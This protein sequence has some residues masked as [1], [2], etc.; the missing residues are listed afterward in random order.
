MRPDALAFP[1]ARTPFRAWRT[2]RTCADEAASQGQEG[3]GHE[4][5]RCGLVRRPRL[6]PVIDDELAREDR[7][8]DELQQAADE[9]LRGRLA[10]DKVG[11]FQ[12]VADPPRCHHLPPE[13]RLN[14]ERGARI[15][16]RRGAEGA[17][18]SGLDVPDA[19]GRAGADNLAHLRDREGDLKGDGERAENLGKEVGVAVRA[20]D[21][22]GAAE[23][24][25]EAGQDDE[26]VLE[27]VP[28][29]KV[30]EDAVYRSGSKAW[31]VRVE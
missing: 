21:V 4:G 20:D 5:G 31:R 14:V 1:N 3:G 25:E 28:A 18:A 11:R 13:P 8:Q 6:A 9:E 16:D 19:R 26:V 22:G 15:R 24:P 2:I 23:R 17:G 30:G 12:D 10:Q 29:P 7:V 27:R